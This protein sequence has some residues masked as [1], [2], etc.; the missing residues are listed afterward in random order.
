MALL[1]QEDFGGVGQFVIVLFGTLVGLGVLSIF[2]S[3]RRRRFGILLAAPG[4]LV[5][6][7]TTVGFFTA[8]ATQESV[9]WSVLPFLLFPLPMLLGVASIGVWV[10]RRD[11]V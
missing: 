2:I 4:M 9:P 8:V 11:G 3:A 10:V 5:S 7:V 1:A 6:L